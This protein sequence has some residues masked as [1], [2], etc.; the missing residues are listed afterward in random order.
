M[1]VPGIFKEL[2][3][4]FILQ[5]KGLFFL[6][7]GLLCL[8]GLRFTEQTGTIGGVLAGFLQMVAGEMAVIIPL[9]VCL[10]GMGNII[11][12]KISNLRTRFTGL[13]VILLLLLVTFHL[14]LMIELPLEG[15]SIY[16]ASYFLGLQKQGGGLTGALLSIVLF[17][18]FG[19]IGSYIV[20]GALAAASFLLVVNISLT[21]LFELFRENLSG[22]L[23][24]VGPFFR[25]L[26]YTLFTE[27]VEEDEEGERGLQ[28]AAGGREVSPD[29]VDLPEQEWE[30]EG[31]CITYGETRGPG[32]GTGKGDTRGKRDTGDE[33]D[34]PGA[35]AAGYVPGAGFED[36]STGEKPRGRGAAAGRPDPRQGETGPGEGR[37]TG[38]E[39]GEAPGRERERDARRGPA[40]G[41]TRVREEK[42]GGSLALTLVLDRGEEEAVPYR[43]PS[44]G[45]LTK[46]SQP[47]DKQ[48]KKIALERAKILENTLRNFGVNVKNIQVYSGPA[49]TRYELQPARG[50]KVSRIVS[51]ADDLALSM[52]AQGVRI[53]APIP[54]KAAVGIE[55]PNKIIAPVYLR[56]VLDNPDFLE[57]ASPLTIGLGKDVYGSPVVVDLARMPH[58]LI[59]GATGSGKSVCLNTL[60]TSLLFKAS[61]REV[62]FLMVDPKFVE[63]NCY[64]GIPHL[65]T[66]V[67]SDSKKAAAALKKMVKEM[68]ERYEKFAREGVREITSYNRLMAQQE[69]GDR[70]LPFIVVIIDELADIMMVSPQEV[71]DA[72]AR[73]AQMARAAGIHLV[74]ATQR[75]SVNVLT[76]IIKANITTRIAFAVSSS[77]DSRVILDMGGAE[78]LVGQGD[79][80][81][82]PVGIQKPRRIQ[83]AYISEEE[84][85]KIVGY[86][87]GQ[88]LE[89]REQKIINESEDQAGE[90]RDLDEVFLEAVQ[91][92]VTSGQASISFLQRKF[93]LGHVRAGRII[94][95][96]E[97]YGI[98][99]GFEGSKS[100]KVLIS[101]EQLS[102][103]LK[104][105]I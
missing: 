54:G 89:P 34:E 8:A 48:Q 87:R 74:I 98:V 37:D 27:E 79:M 58:L 64:N 77:T 84:V 76:G 10:L 19:E 45:L 22:L 70:V 33:G 23:V 44:L 12:W 31:T 80:L 52:A 15:E 20:V 83:G 16:R 13:M 103:L 32:E 66:P 51:L 60:I 93:H 29:G 59:A 35:G 101:P 104:K 88:G 24:K 97:R 39:P 82:H 85:K 3:D 46:G 73:L 11:P 18:F 102:E 40:R 5:L 95:D 28:L 4:D 30:E 7:L 14:N 6:A 38:K 1:A 75:P 2:K 21:G 53:E 42:G 55:V 100:R 94:D 67:I 25:E 41:P 36:T 49:V 71:E 57:A 69:E 61:P 99:S 86:I 105:I 50:V 17:F 92:V 9:L 91:E 81:Y 26:Y 68:G 62:R 96:M 78:K 90:P 65:L 47:R 72:I 56:G 63:L 43:L